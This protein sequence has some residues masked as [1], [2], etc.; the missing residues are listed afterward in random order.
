MP[1]SRAF[2]DVCAKIQGQVMSLPLDDLESFEI[3]HRARLIGLFPIFPHIFMDARVWQNDSVKKRIV[4]YEASNEK[5]QKCLRQEICA[6]IWNNFSRW[7]VDL[8]SLMTTCVLVGLVPLN[9]ICLAS[10]EHVKTLKKLLFEH[11]VGDKTAVR[12][13]IDFYREALTPS[14]ETKTSLVIPEGI[15]NE[16]HDWYNSKIKERYIS[17]LRSVDMTILTAFAIDRNIKIGEASP[18]RLA[19]RIY[20]YL[21]ATSGG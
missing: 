17:K 10:E 6:K 4:I 9:W 18:N 20:K 1:P 16:P 15:Y 11:V 19:R 21:I 2:V 13:F 8:N 12:R 14:P 5:E 7:T 3:K